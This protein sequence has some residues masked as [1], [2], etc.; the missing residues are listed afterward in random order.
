MNMVGRKTEPRGQLIHPMTASSSQETVNC[1]CLAC[2]QHLYTCENAWAQI[3]NTYYACERPGSFG[4]AGLVQAE[5]TRAGSK[6][7]EL[8]GCIVQPLRCEKCGTALG[9][10]C[11]ETPI[12]KIEYK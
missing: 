5:Q 1:Y 4:R 11:I 12:A 7:S 6:G 3:S 2:N 8:E 10:E 9:L